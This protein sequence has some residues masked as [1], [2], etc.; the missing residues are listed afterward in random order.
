MEDLPFGRTAA[1]VPE[2][3]VKDLPL[4]RTHND[5]DPHYKAMMANRGCE[6]KESC[7]CSH[8]ATVGR[9]RVAIPTLGHLYPQESP[10]THFA[11]GLMVPWANLDMG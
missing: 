1:F 3:A 9:G 6:C 5:D 7:I 4:G 10:S 2:F 8:G 11:G